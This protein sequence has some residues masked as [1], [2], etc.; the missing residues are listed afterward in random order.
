MI[1]IITP[2]NKLMKYF[3]STIDSVM[4]QTYDDFEWVILD[5]SIDEITF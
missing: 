4:A 3:D 2:T 1:S 5:N